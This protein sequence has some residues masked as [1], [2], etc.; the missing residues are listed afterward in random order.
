[1]ISASPMK[2]ERPMF[3]TDRFVNRGT[4]IDRRFAPRQQEVFRAESVIE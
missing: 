1:M 2:R 3:L 4:S